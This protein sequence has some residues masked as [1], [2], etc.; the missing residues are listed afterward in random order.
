MG[1]TWLVTLAVAI[2]LGALLVY[3]GHRAHVERRERFEHREALPFDVWFEQYYG[4]TDVSQELAKELLELLADDIGVAPTKIRPSDKI[5][6]DL[7]YKHLWYSVD[8]GLDGF[9]RGLEGIICR[10]AAGDLVISRDCKT[11]G[12]LIHIISASRKVSQ[13]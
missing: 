8:D 13:G 12:D 9:D 4:G 1:L 3:L 6:E 5:V 11:L 2:A 7:S 10:Y